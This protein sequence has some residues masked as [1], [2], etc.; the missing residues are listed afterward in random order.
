MAEVSVLHFLGPVEAK[1]VKRSHPVSAAVLRV[2]GGE[3]QTV[4]TIS[5]T[6]IAA[7]SLVRL[8][9]QEWKHPSGQ[10]LVVRSSMTTAIQG[11]NRHLCTRTDVVLVRLIRLLTSHRNFAFP[12]VRLTKRSFASHEHLT[13]YFTINTGKLAI[14]ARLRKTPSPK[15]S[16]SRRGTK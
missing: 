15:P 14:K 11:S 10:R 1:C 4:Q 2:K 7:R 13:F 12:A 16:M 9:D 3:V 6:E 8:G 5:F